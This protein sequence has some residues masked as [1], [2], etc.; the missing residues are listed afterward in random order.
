MLRKIKFKEFKKLYRKNIIRDFPKNERPNLENFR[1]RILT[2]KEEVYIFEEEGIEKGYCIIAQLEN[3]IFVDFLATYKESR[4]QG[5]GTKIIK[6]LI[7][8]YPNYNILLEVEDPKFAK[9]EKEKSIREKRIKFYE[10]SNF[11]MIK[12]LQIKYSDLVI[13][14]LMIFSIKEQNIQEIREEIKNFYSKIQNKKTLRKI[15]IKDI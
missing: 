2:N 15:E 14:K 1:K 13:F 12:E 9:D 5:V 4:G 6:E 3:Y 7:E 10:K 8:K 11:K